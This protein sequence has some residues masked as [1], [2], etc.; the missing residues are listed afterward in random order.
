LA[1][2]TD[3]WWNLC[4]R[5]NL[6][7]Y[8]RTLKREGKSLNPILKTSPKNKSNRKEKRAR[9]SR[10]M[11]WRRKRKSKRKNREFLFQIHLLYFYEFYIFIS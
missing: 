6:I 7:K 11:Y 1:T 5:L 3:S 10:K 2:D 9:E 4:F 8:K